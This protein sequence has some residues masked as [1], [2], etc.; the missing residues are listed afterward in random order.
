MENR[1]LR[2]H[3]YDA[4]IVGT[5]GET[6]ITVFIEVR[7]DIGAYQHPGTSS[8][9]HGPDVQ[10]MKP[11][12]TSGQGLAV[13]R[14]NAQPEATITFAPDH[15]SGTLDAWFGSRVGTLPPPSEPP[16]T[17]RVYGTWRCG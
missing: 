6:A 17:T 8:S 5:V 11:S 16:N 7:K 13:S 9:V 12:A 1:S 2:P 14:D 15:K 3:F 10:L 4:V